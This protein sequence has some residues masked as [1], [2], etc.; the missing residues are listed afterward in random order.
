MCVRGLSTADPVPTIA[1]MLLEV[2]VRLE[3]RFRGKV[4]IRVKVWA[5]ARAGL[6]LQGHACGRGLSTAGAA[7]ITAPTL[8]EVT[9]RV[10]Q[11]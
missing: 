6:A 2:S 10:S 4:T 7:W 9:R 3:V 8:V 11:G 1:P 5:I